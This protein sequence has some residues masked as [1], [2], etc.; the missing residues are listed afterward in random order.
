MSE[1]EKRATVGIANLVDN[2]ADVAPRERVAIVCDE[3]R[4]DPRV[5][6]LIAEAVERAGGRPTTTWFDASDTG[7]TERAVAATRNTEKTIVSSMGLAPFLA[8]GVPQPAL[9][10]GSLFHSLADFAT[11]HA[12]FHWKMADEIY[13]IV[14]D[15]FVTG[16]NW[17]IATP[18]GTD[19]S[20]TVC[21]RSARSSYLEDET[22]AHTRYFHS[23]AFRPVAADSS[24]GTIVCQFTHGPRRTPCVPPPV[25]AFEDNQLKAITG[26]DGAR[27]WIDEL[28]SGF[29]SVLE[30]FGGPGRVLDSW[31]GGANPKAE[32]APT[33]LGNGS[34]RNMHFHIGR[35]TGRSGDY[36]SAE[37]SDYSLAVNGRSVF[38]RGRLA[39]LGDAPVQAAFDRF[40][41]REPV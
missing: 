16:A 19:L 21:D 13:R 5:A 26:P 27:R 11:S 30:R 41:L 31:H 36:I 37:I 39:I 35:T 8:P 12:A 29:D 7:S 15:L 24:D 33:L 38:D 34:T 9:I 40:G 4:V 10:V 22:P 32:L 18:T 6:K 3:T 17:R 14:E 23:R 28:Q 25:L 20:G 1:I 2:C